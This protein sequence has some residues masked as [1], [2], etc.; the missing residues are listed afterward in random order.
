VNLQERLRILQRGLKNYAAAEVRGTRCRLVG[1]RADTGGARVIANHE[2]EAHADS[3]DG[4]REFR[5]R[6]ELERELRVVLWPDPDD[7][8]VTPINEKS[9]DALPSPATAG[10]RNRVASLMEAGFKVAGV[11]MPHQVLAEM[12]MQHGVRLAM[13]VSF[14]VD[15]GCLTLAHHGHPGPRPAYLRWAGDWCQATAGSGNTLSRYEFAA[16]FAPHMRRLIKT[17]T[18]PQ[19]PIL[20]CGTM[21]NLRTAMAP[22]REEFGR[23]VDVLDHPWPGM[24]DAE[25]GTIPTEPAAWQ[26][27]RAAAQS[28]AIAR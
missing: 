23:D 20:A 1:V 12:A 5:R 22:F 4:L 8:G 27:A 21:P 11:A 13:T 2:C 7:A 18:S 10:I 19:M 15:G 16:A 14:H 24:L 26:I 28:A 25:A 6:H 17:A 9:E 3:I